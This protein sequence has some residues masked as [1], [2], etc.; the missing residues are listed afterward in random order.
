MSGEDGRPPTTPDDG[1]RAASPSSAASG[2]DVDM[3]RGTTAFG[4]AVSWSFVLT[5]GRTFMTLIVSL[6]LARILGP[7]AF[8]LIAMANVFILFAELFVR[9]GLV[10]AIVQ[11][12][13]LTA[14]HLDT[15]FWMTVML[16]AVLVPGA[17]G[18]SGWWAAANDTPELAELITALVPL[19]VFKAL[20]VAQEAHIRRQ[21]NF[22][23][24]ALRTNVAVLTGGAAGITAALLGAGVWSLVIQ[25]L[26]TAF[27]ELVL[28]WLLSS[29]RPRWRFRADAARDLLS[30]SA[31]MVLAAL[32]S[33]VNS[34]SDAL[35]IGLFFGPLLVGLYRMAVRFI[36]IMLEL[37]SGT[38]Q[39]VMLPELSRFTEDRSAF[40]ARTVEVIRLASL[41][42]VPV[43][44]VL[45]ASSDALMGL[46]GDEWAPAADALKVLCILAV[47]QAAAAFLAPI[48][49]AAGRPGLL[50]WLTWI[51]A[52]LSAG[53]FAAAGL[54]LGGFDV[55]DQVL[56]LAI[57]RTAVFVPSLFLIVLPMLKGALG[58]R[59]TRVL[60]AMWR[61]PI[62]AAAG[63]TGFALLRT[64]AG[65]AWPRL[66]LID[67]LASA[68]VSGT[69]IIVVL[70]AIEPLVR[71]VPAL[72]RERF[73]RRSAPRPDPTAPPDSGSRPDASI[74]AE[75]E[76]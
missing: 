1:E 35:L 2:P 73:A 5:S 41:L 30:F 52:G 22:R 27:L 12:P 14:A 23:A 21:M 70:L 60:G 39:L 74:T 40:N 33:F 19:L 37:T 28:I 62:A 44:G 64:T 69:I 9:Q 29:W 34:H 57:I 24:L 6:V 67:L 25:Q 53:S 48:L 3:G 56:W 55:E 59:P 47:V 50:A 7:E 75:T 51:S 38:L 36:G 49:Q 66:P 71:E 45:A 8:G 43:L 10:S 17:I 61:A 16:A 15:A 46:L 11:R 13:K 20:G 32:G 72:I 76:P 58:L 68:T 31:R 65:S 26:V 54:W 4:T 18:A 42:A 63:Y